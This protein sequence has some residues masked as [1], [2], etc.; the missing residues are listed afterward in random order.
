ML[1]KLQAH[2][3]LWRQFKRGPGWVHVL[4][5][6]GWGFIHA[7]LPR[8]IIGRPSVGPAPARGRADRRFS[9]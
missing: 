9:R 7:Q 3:Y 5:G 6:F 1:F 2:T 8:Y 4:A